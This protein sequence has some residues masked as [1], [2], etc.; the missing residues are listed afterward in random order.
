LYT[1][2]ACTYNK[3]LDL[4]KTIYIV[5]SD[6][7]GT[8][9]VIV[10]HTTYIVVKNGLDRPKIIPT[11]IVLVYLELYQEDSYYEISIAEDI[12]YLTD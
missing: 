10:D 3:V 6:F 4:G 2:L 11:N 8:L 7:P 9:D 12:V 5:Y 1:V